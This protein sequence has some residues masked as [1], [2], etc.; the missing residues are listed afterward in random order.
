MEGRSFI[1][2]EYM[3]INIKHGIA[4]IIFDERPF[5]ISH[6]HHYHNRN[7]YIWL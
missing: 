7:R 4:Q 3:A 5:S 1:V 2:S 6:H